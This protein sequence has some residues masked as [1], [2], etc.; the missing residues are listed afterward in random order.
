MVPVVTGLSQPSATRPTDY[1]HTLKP[2]AKVEQ[3][4][5]VQQQFHNR[6]LSSYPVIRIEACFRICCQIQSIRIVTITVEMYINCV[7]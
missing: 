7:L 3:F 2:H 5:P 1:A 6:L 4:L